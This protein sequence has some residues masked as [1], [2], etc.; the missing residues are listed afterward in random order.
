MNQKPEERGPSLR[1]A[2]CYALIALGVI[3]LVFVLSREAGDGEQSYAFI[4][5]LFIQEKV[6]YFEVSSTD[7]LTVRLHEPLIPGGEMVY[8]HHLASPEMFYADLGDTIQE[9]LSRGILTDYNYK[10]A[11]KAPWWLGMVPP[12]LAVA[13]VMVFL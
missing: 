9:Q 3:G 13:A 4:R 8:Y 6:E 5:R 2:L 1:S 12:L 10:A 7:E 11:P